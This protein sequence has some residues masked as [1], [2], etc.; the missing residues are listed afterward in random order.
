MKTP[1]VKKIKTL[2]AASFEV[3]NKL[4]RTDFTMKTPEKCQEGMVTTNIKPF[5]TNYVAAARQ[6]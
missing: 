6:S 3:A 5:D 1:K 2:L 4:H